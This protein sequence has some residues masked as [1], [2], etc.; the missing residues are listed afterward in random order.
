MCCTI[1]EAAE[2]VDWLRRV[3]RASPEAIA[4]VTEGLTEKDVRDH[5]V[6]ALKAAGDNH[7]AMLC[8]R[9]AARR[10]SLC[11]TDSFRTDSFQL[12]E[13]YAEQG[14]LV[15]ALEAI[16]GQ[17]DAAA[18]MLRR[19]IMEQFADAY[20]EYLLTPKD[21][22]GDGWLG[23]AAAQGK[24]SSLLFTINRSVGKRKTSEKKGRAPQLGT[25]QSDS[26]R[27][28]AM[29]GDLAR[30]EKAMREDS[31][32]KQE[33][34]MIHTVTVEGLLAHIRAVTAF[35]VFV[36][37]LQVDI[38]QVTNAIHAPLPFRITLVTHRA[39]AS[40]SAA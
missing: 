4:K 22:V 34:A 16:N 9:N 1:D 2:T 10:E 36:G 6:P 38:C 17:M 15:E 14:Y 29:R 25:K 23:F 19:Q 35:P 20:T 21:R 18:C 12:A 33:A 39:D 28:K 26:V 24:G 27:L 11:G 5:I 3:G 31:R 37:M 7:Q 8:L 40:L 32:R 13:L 30:I